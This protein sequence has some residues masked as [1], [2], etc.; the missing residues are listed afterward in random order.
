MTR[1]EI[2]KNTLLNTEG[3]EKQL[4]GLREHDFTKTTTHEF[5][6]DQDEVP[7]LLKIADDE[8]Y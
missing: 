3:P 7:S 1:L 2:T 4:I 6:I 5:G 8:L